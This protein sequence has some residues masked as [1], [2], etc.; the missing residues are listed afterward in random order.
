MVQEYYEAG[1][2]NQADEAGPAESHMS[3]SDCMGGMQRYI[4]DLGSQII[5]FTAR[6]S[7]PHFHKGFTGENLY[8]IT[9]VV[10]ECFKCT[11]TCWRAR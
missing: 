8:G 6:Y 11:G 2:D 7:T 3:E 10:N 4:A 9:V 5:A 1:I